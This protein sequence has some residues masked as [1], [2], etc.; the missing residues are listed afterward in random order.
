[1][2]TLLLIRW[3]NRHTIQKNRGRANFFLMLTLRS[4]A[5]H[6]VV[7]PITVLG[8]DTKCATDVRRFRRP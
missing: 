3:N 1:M 2:A 7:A 5:R 6:A 4:C 8:W